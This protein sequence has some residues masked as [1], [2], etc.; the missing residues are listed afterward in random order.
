MES[1]AVGESDETE[2]SAVNE[3]E[4]DVAETNT[5]S[6]VAEGILLRHQNTKE[7]E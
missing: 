3:A 7:K 2:S 4:S 6:S 1:S 5:E